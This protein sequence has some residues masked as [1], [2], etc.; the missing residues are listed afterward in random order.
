[1]DLEA[2]SAFFSLV[3]WV[4]GGFLLL[5]HWALSWLFDPGIA[6]AMVLFGWLWVSGML[7]LDGLLDLADALPAAV[8]PD[9]RLEILRDVHLGSF[10]L[11]IGVVY[12]VLKWQALVSLAAF[13]PL[14]F[15]PAWARF[16]VLLLARIYAPAKRS[17]LGAALGRG[18][19]GLGFIFA[20]PIVLIAPLA[21]L[22]SLLSAFLLAGYARRRLGG[23]T[24]DVYGAAIEV[25]ELVFLLVADA[26]MKLGR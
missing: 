15:A 20:L 3:G 4:I 7:H 24:G 25:S 11:G 1:M 13:W 5:I 18:R 19:L 22:F 17:G 21:A 12:L 26:L 9:R 16:A 8:S 2:A 6:A 14:L 23:L 10:A